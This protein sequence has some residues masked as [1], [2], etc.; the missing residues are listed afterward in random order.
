MKRLVALITAAIV[1]AS[2]GLVAATPIDKA[3]DKVSSPLQ[4]AGRLNNA[5]ST[6]SFADAPPPPPASGLSTELQS[7]LARTNAERAARGLAP[8]VHNP[9]LT[10]AAAAHSRDQAARNQLT[11]T[12]SDGSNPG[13]RIDRT[14]YQWRTWAENAASGFGTAEGVM[15][16]WMQSAGHRRNILNPDVTEIGLGLAYSSSGYPYWTQV[17]AA[18]K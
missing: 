7:V 4:G 10:I 2:G 6:V 1:L 11:H 8:L 16:G 13:Q 17:F 9:L 18:P 5:T 15:V 12:G 3:I 14:G